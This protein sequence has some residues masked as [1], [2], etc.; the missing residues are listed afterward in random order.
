VVVDGGVVA[1]DVAALT[2]A[3]WVCLGITADVVVADAD[4][5]VE[6]AVA[7]TVAGGES[8]GITVVGSNQENAMRT[9]GGVE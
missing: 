5:V 8:F 2:D 7:L 3:V 9:A 4:A 1:V 6:G